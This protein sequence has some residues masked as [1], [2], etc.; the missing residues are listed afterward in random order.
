MP[1]SAPIDPEGALVTRNL[2]FAAVLR[3]FEFELHKHNPALIAEE[4]KW[5]DLR[6][7]IKPAKPPKRVTWRFKA[8]YKALPVANAWEAAQAHNDFE[9]YVDQLEIDQRHKD[10]LKEL[11]SASV[12]RAGREILEHRQQLLAI[13][14]SAPQ[15]VYWQ[16]I[17]Y[18]NGQVKSVFPKAAS[19]EVKA[20]FLERE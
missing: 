3:F 15:S 6:K 4:I 19:A 9:K 12:A 5:S 10:K 18:D 20:K 1:A 13:L 14:A 2:D 16:R 17:L 8:D 7:G 11:H